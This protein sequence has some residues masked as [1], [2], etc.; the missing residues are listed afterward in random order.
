VARKNEPLF[1][2][3]GISA[4]ATSLRK[5]G[6]TELSAE[7]KAVTKEA[8]E[9]V[10]PYAK[11]RVPVQTGRL[12][13]SIKAEGTRRFARIKAG[14]TKRVPYARAIHSGRNIGSTGK[15][16]KGTPFIAKAIPEAWPQIVDEF[17][18]G[19]NRIA[20]KFEK[21]HG[22]SRYIGRYKK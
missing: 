20:K 7:M 11:K 4:L 2:A 6:D 10:V 3:G 12:Q 18:K 5:I 21:K 8:A 15:R 1:R 16:T 19:M 9:K 13:A 22:A 14:T 17:V